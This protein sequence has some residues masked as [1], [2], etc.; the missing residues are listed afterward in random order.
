MLSSTRSAKSRIG[1]VGKYVELSD[2]Y[3]SLIEA[4]MHAG[5]KTRTKVKIEYLDSE[6]IETGGTASLDAV[7]AILVPGG[8][9]KRGT[10]GKIAGDSLRA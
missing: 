9:G 5:I 2:S 7:D 3:K 6:Q 8:F 1:M 10:E 4:L